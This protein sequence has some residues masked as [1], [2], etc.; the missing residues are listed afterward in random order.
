M[1]EYKRV[2]FL[3]KNTD[4]HDTVKELAKFGQIDVYSERNEHKV[5]DNVNYYPTKEW[6]SDQYDF[7]VVVDALSNFLDNYMKGNIYVWL[8]NN[9]DLEWNGVKIGDALLYNIDTFISGW[10]TSFNT[11]QLN[12]VIDIKNVDGWK[13]LFGLNFEMEYKDVVNEISQSENNSY[14][15]HSSELLGNTKI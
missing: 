15:L 8:K 11:N 2:A 14:F 13:N 12:N 9:A 4:I 5:R 6:K 3:T 10:I 1:S 7:Y